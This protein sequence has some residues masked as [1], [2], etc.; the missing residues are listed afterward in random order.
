MATK[1][2]ARPIP[3]TVHSA[4]GWSVITKGKCGHRV[5]VYVG[6]DKPNEIQ[7]DN[8][9]HRGLKWLC[10]RCDSVRSY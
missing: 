9:V 1:V 4:H 8:A 10:D 2:R 5:V 3:Y 6:F 7:I